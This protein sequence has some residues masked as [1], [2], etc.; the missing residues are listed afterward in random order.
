[1]KNLTPEMIEKAKAAKTAEE[2]L[3]LAKAN[4]VEMTA[5]EAKIYFAQ[6]T[7]KSGEIDDNDLDNV[8][9]GACVSH[10]TGRT[11]VTSG[12]QCFTG[13]FQPNTVLSPE[14]F[15]TKRS[16]FLSNYFARTD[17]F[18]RRALWCSFAGK[19]TCGSCIHLEFEGGTGVCGKS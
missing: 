12:C 14:E 13:Q 5:D 2:L 3:E 7:P 8:S 15:A 18:E 17:S 16:E 19:D 6:L 4:G 1:M 9:G 11:V 10:S